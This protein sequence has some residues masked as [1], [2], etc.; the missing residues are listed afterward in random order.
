[1]IWT[2]NPV[3]DFERWDAQQQAELDELPKCSECGEP[4]QYEG[5][6]I[7]NDWVCENCMEQY[8]K[9]VW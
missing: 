2:D 8:R 3:A 7:I 4:I 6:Y 9:K 1:M 5:Y